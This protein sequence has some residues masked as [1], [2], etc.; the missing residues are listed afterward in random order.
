MSSFFSGL[1]RRAATPLKRTVQGNTG[2]HVEQ[3]EPRHLCAVEVTQDGTY[4]VVQGTPDVGSLDVQHQPSPGNQYDDKVLIS[5]SS[6]GVRQSRAFDLY[7]QVERG[8]Q[9]LAVKNV[10]YLEVS[11]GGGRN[12]FWSQTRLSSF[13]TDSTETRATR[14][15]TFGNESEPWQIT[16][17]PTVIT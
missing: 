8:N 3:L 11:S 9:R 4:I 6:G 12:Q 13:L 7:K 17:S 2:L 5:W 1:F 16:S 15:V 14:A 10:E